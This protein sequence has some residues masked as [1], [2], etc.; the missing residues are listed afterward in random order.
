MHACACVIHSCR[1]DA[2]VARN[3]ALTE[4]VSLL[5]QASKTTSSRSGTADGTGPVDAPRGS[6]LAAGVLRGVGHRRR[7]RSGSIGGGGSG[8][9][10]GGSEA[11]DGGSVDAAVDAATAGV[12]L[13]RACAERDAFRAQLHD[14]QRQ[15]SV[16]KQAYHRCEQELNKLVLWRQD[17]EGRERVTRRSLQQ[18][19]SGTC[20][21]AS[22]R[23]PSIH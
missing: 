16:S 8:G 21:R 9:G 2:L 7:R 6:A 12:R 10:G 22:R 20:R 11:S 18:E 17:Q 19:L 15:L 23:G 14:S 5:Q 1:L 4:Q 3:D 13:A